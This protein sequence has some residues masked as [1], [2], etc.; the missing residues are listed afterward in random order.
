MLPFPAIRLFGSTPHPVRDNLPLIL[1]ALILIPVVTIA[2][3]I[4][5]T[6]IAPSILVGLLIPTRGLSS[7]VRR[8]TP[9]CGPADRITLF[10]MVL[11]GGVGALALLSLPDIA[12][13]CPWATLMLAIPAI[14]LDG[15]DGYVARRTGTASREGAEFDVEADSLLVLALSVSAAVVVG[16]WVVII[17]LMRYGYVALAKGSPSLRRPLPRCNLRRGIG[18]VQPIALCVALVPGVPGP[19][20]TAV[21]GIALALLM[22]SF[23][24][25]IWTQTRAC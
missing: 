20:S 18:I 8:P 2:R 16:W 15:V 12:P 17:G 11:T 13:V 14:G 19:V 21:A 1:L 4:P 6:V 24:R 3:G 7:I 22:Y 5:A 10:R 9:F 25:D 23:G